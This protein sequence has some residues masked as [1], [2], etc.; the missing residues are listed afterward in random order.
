MTK[1][2]EH[3]LQSK[4][5]N[6][7]EEGLFPIALTIAGSDSGGGAGLQADLKTFSACGVHGT[8]IVTLITAQNTRGVSA[9]EVLSR[10]LIRAQFEALSS[11]VRALAAKT[12]ALGDERGVKIVAE[13]LAEWPVEKLVVDPVM[14]SK[15]GDALMPPAAQRLVRDY[16]L[17]GALLVTP[18]RFEAEALSG[19]EVGSVDSM[20]EAARRIHDFGVKH[21]LIKGAHFD[22]IV[23][24]I[25]YDG[26][27][28]LEFGADRIDSDRVHGSG[29]TFSAAITARLARGDELVAAIDFARRFIS[30]AITHARRVGAGISP[31]N[32]MYEFWSMRD[33]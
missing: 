7:Q 4:F 31:V 5:E 3:F 32:P 13:C 23:R 2:F 29:C 33:F 25:F 10:P 9:I 16:L 27:D 12:G 1:S 18:N 21:V 19:Q 30:A 11:D 28:F 15:H 14:M 20:K 22:K 17:D 26:R 8:S 6:P 24:D